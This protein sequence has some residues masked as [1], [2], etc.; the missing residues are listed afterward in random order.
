MMTYQLDEY[1][2]YSFTEYDECNLQFELSPDALLT[3]DPFRFR[4]TA[5]LYLRQRG[6]TV[7]DPDEIEAAQL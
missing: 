7:V 4:E 3:L 1:G 2:P 5:K 6:C